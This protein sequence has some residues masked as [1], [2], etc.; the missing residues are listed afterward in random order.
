MPTGSYA[1][2]ISAAGMTINRTVAVTDD[3]AFGYQI[4]LA[5]GTAVTE[6][7]KDD[8]DTATCTLPVDHGYS[9]GKFDVF[10][11][12]GC[13]Y[14]VD[15]TVAGNGLA[16]D[17]G[18]G[19]DFP[20]DETAV[21]VCPPV[22][23][24]IEIDGD[25]LSLFAIESTVLANAWFVDSTNTEVVSLKLAGSQPQGFYQT[26]DAESPLTGNVCEK[27]WVSNGSTTPGQVTIIG[28]QKVSA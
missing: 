27:V 20:A 9:T 15:G 3:N 11:D 22:Y 26:G 24:D 14:D 21:V 28:L 18:S 7:D 1:V 4:N 19:N 8:A 23:L 5:A 6:W 17:G 10:W 16:L 2:V 13:R 25:N 12:G